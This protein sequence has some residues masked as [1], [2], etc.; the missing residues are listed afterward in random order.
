MLLT[1]RFATPAEAES[2][3]G[4]HVRFTTGLSTR[5]GKVRKGQEGVV[6]GVR[7]SGLTHVLVVRVSG[8]GDV[9]VG[10]LDAVELI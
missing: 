2:L 1:K 5:T 3:V 10:N 9:L 8:V 7:R 6:A 4:S